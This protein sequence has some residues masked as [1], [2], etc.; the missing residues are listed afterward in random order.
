MRKFLRNIIIFSGVVICLLI[1]GE[2]IVRKLPS[3]YATKAGYIKNHGDEIATLILGSSHTYYGLNPEEMGDSVFNLAN[4]SQTPEYDLALLEHFSGYIPHLR[5]LILPVSYFTYVDPEIEK[6]EAWTLG[7][8]YK[9]RMG[10]PLHSDMSVYNL[11]LA[12][13]DSYKGQ[14]SNI[15]KKAPSNVSSEKGFGLNYNLGM[16]SPNW[17][18]EGKKRAE[19]HTVD[20]P[21]RGEKVVDVQRKLLDLAK[22]RGWQVIFITT[23]GYKSYTDNLD[24][25]QEKMMRHYIEQLKKE[26]NIIYLDLLR[27]KRFGEDDF[28]DPDHL[29]DVGAAKLSKIIKETRLL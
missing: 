16:R 1:A 14:L 20:N 3:S 23:P 27:D 21:E 29:S 10:L 15:I 24:P 17:K 8:K 28:Y 26:Y 11:E 6:S 4:I 5:T 18:E 7:I 2:F 19:A 13:F 25:A 9:T 12:D 22:S